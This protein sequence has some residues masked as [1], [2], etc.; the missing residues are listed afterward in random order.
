MKLA[1]QFATKGDVYPYAYRDASSI[2]GDTDVKRNHLRSK[3]NTVIF[4]NIYE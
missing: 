3:R 1:W 4:E 2:N